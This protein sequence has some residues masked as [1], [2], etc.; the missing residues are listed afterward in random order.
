M[1]PLI[2]F[3]S[4]ILLK[5]AMAETVNFIFYTMTIFIKF[6]T[7]NILVIA[8]AD[9]NQH[10]KNP[11]NVVL[12]S[13]A[14]PYKLT[15]FVLPLKFAVTFAVSPAVIGTKSEKFSALLPT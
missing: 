15:V 14:E 6:M 8:N 9:M 3:N 5:S 13:P 10:T 4:E 7:L 2:L 12:G 11:E 1:I